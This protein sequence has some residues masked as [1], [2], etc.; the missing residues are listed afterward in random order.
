MTVL[1]RLLGHDTWTTRQLLLRCRELSDEQMDRSFDIGARSLRHT[2]G[3]I[4]SCMEMHVDRMLGRSVDEPNRGAST[5]DGFLERLTDVG[6]DFSEIASRV[7]RSGTAD[8]MCPGPDNTWPLGAGIAHLLTHSMH[9][10]A[11][12]MYI[13]DQLG[14]EN[15]IEGDAFGW[16]GQA[17]GWGYD[18]CGSYG[19]VVAG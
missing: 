15:I 4:L 7:D 10:R 3:H 18:L 8:D 5:I 14:L 13:M 16:E 12:A 11:Q 19:K 9:H 6:K 2:F 17:R 1:D